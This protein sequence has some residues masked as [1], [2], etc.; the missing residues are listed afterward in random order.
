MADD[1]TA[2]ESLAELADEPGH[3]PQAQQDRS[4]LAEEG[5]SQVIGLAA[6]EDRTTSGRNRLP[7]PN[8]TASAAAR[9]MS[10]RYMPVVSAAGSS[11]STPAL[12]CQQ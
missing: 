3:D 1:A 6:E 2:H 7:S 4:K 8:A 5:P 10:V 9:I 11:S 12:V